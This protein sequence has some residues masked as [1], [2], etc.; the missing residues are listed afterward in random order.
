VRE[1]DSVARYGGEEFV[2]VMPEAGEAEAA[3]LAERL[4]RRIADEPFAQRRITISLGVAQ[5]P[6]QG[7]TADAVIAAA[8]AALYEAKRSGRNRVSQAGKRPGQ[9]EKSTR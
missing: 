2:V 8:D 5:Y 4:R 7:E 9:T 6:A 1:V 3:R